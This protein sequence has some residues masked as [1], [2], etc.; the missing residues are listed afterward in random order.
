M[1]SI[2]IYNVAILL[3]FGAGVYIGTKYDCRPCMKQV[4]SHFIE[5]F[6]KKMIVTKKKKKNKYIIYNYK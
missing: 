3:G 2:Y 1:L 4:E 6:L 5:Y